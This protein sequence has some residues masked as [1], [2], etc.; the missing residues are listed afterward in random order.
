MSWD[1]IERLSWLAGIVGAVVAALAAWMAARATKG[2]MRDLALI[3]SVATDKP[4]LF[5]AIEADARKRTE[6]VRRR[7]RAVFVAAG[8]AFAVSAFGAAL[9]L[10]MLLMPD[11]GQPEVVGGDQPRVTQECTNGGEATVCVADNRW[12]LATGGTVEAQFGGVERKTPKDGVARLVLQ[13]SGC[14]AAGE[15]NWTASVGGSVV[16]EGVAR[17]SESRAE[18]PLKTG[19][20][21]TFAVRRVGGGDCAVDLRLRPVVSFG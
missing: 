6:V 16:A 21:F 2:T 1:L 18:F 4:E 15:L 19:E 13:V 7:V 3:L 14:S 17:E 8:A 10:L 9:G 20:G 11:Y 12:T 5:E